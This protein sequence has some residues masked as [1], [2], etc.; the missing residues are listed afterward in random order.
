[1]EEEDGE[2]DTDQEERESVWEDV[3]RECPFL[4]ELNNTKVPPEQPGHIARSGEDGV[5]VGEPPTE[6][7]TG[8]LTA[9]ANVQSGES[10]EGDSGEDN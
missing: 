2:E 8:V 1:M 4:M 3:L 6:T 10:E 9:A 7:H 5:D